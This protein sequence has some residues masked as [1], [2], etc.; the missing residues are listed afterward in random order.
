MRKPKYSFEQWCIDNDRQDLLNRWDYEKNV[1][2][3]SDVGYMSESSFWFKCQ[4]GKHESEPHRIYNI[5]NSKNPMLRCSKCR[6]F[7]QYIIDE[8]GED[9]LN[10]VWSDKNEFSPWDYNKTKRIDAY[11][12]CENNPKHVYSLG[13]D[14]FA[15]GQRCPYCAGKR[16]LKEESL[17]MVYPDSLKYWSDRNDKT[18]Y[19]YTTNS[20]QEVWWKCPNGKHDDF[21]RMVQN[22]VRYNFA[23]HDCTLEQLKTDGVNNREDM[24]GQRFSELTVTRYAYTGDD[25]RA[26]WYCDCDCGAT[27]VIKCGQLLR[28]GKT[29][30][31]GNKS[32]HR[33]AENNGNWKGGITPENSL[34]RSSAEYKDWRTNVFKKDNYTCQSCGSC[35]GCLNAHHI[36]DFATYEELRLDVSNG[37]TLCPNCHDTK[38]ED[39]LHNIY[40]CIGVTEKELEEYI[41]NKRKRLGIPIPFNI[42]DYKDG[43]RLNKDSIKEIEEFF[44][45]WNFVPYLA[46][47]IRPVKQDNGFAKIKPKFRIKED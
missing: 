10:F 35:S 40:G 28:Q 8:F 26:Y 22:S 2:K 43:N 37:I 45:V 47:G 16:V 14:H 44:K 42:D 21:H 19:D 17:G 15:I 39:S 30:S 36:K 27:D 11:F 13:L 33:T 9:Y 7:A 34:I 23:C 18:P 38:C 4:N 5:S 29:T 31:C 20:M 12:N 46:G 3:P 24:T 25:N 41:N 6:T 1:D 32:V